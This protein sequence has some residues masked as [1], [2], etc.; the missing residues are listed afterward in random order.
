MGAFLL[1]CVA[2]L[3]LPAGAGPR[4]RLEEIQRRQE[5]IEQAQ[6]S[7]STDTSRLAQRV[8]ELDA[9]RAKV[10]ER[11]DSLDAIIGRLDADIAGKREALTVAQQEVALLAG[12]LK[13]IGIRLDKRLSVYR[14]RAI[15]AYVAGP[16]AAVD[17]LLSAQSFSDLVERSAYY[18]SALDADSELIGEIEILQ[19]DTEY[20]QEQ[21]EKHKTKIAADKLRLESARAEVADARAARAEELSTQEAVISEKTSLLEGLRSR[22]RRLQEVETQLSSESQGI[23]DLLAREAA[24]EAA[25]QAEAAPGVGS[26][27]LGESPPTIGGRLL[28]PAT[29]PITSSFGYRV[30]PIFGTTRMHTGIDIGA[31]YGSSVWAAED[32]IVAYVG[33]M[34]GYGNVV[35]I[36]HGQSLA[37]T[38]NH[39]S[40]FYVGIGQRVTRGT[41]I[42]AV[43]CTGYCTGPHL[44]FEVRVNG[45]PVDPVPYLR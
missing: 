28:F 37:T 24:A 20:K 40:A 33:T 21:V 2:G 32:G 26:P 19:A 30:H 22:Q 44:H 39:L 4:D 16:T 34:S 23:T 14:E 43:G 8:L 3:A 25:A 13:T 29:G 12:D 31:A 6:Q 11:V 17:G 5:R 1:L 35:V 10:Q 42:A 27:P 18:Q 15:A 9:E 41:P 7:L 36:D 45:T 38:Y